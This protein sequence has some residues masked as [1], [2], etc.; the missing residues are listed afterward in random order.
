MLFRSS[1]RQNLFSR[2]EM[3]VHQRLSEASLSTTEL[4]DLYRSELSELFGDAVRIP[5]EYR[6]EWSTI[7]HIHESP[8][9]VY[10]YNFGNLL[11]LALYQCYLEEG[12]I[13]KEKLKNFLSSGSSDSPKVLCEAIGVDISS[14]AFWE[15]SLT[16]IEGLIDECERL[17]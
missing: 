7:P 1:H 16:Y 8:F 12:A 17:I 4:C 13:F 11:V 5:D 10:S 15:K 2:F 9:Y 3:A 6:W 14:Q